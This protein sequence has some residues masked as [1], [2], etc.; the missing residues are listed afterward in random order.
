MKY[1]GRIFGSLGL[2]LLHSVYIFYYFF[3]DGEVEP[4]DLYSYPLLIWIGYWGGK[5]FDKVRFYSEKDELTGIYNRRFV[6]NTY[7]KITSIAERTN[8]KL[9]VLVID[10]DNFKAINDTYGHHNGDMVLIKISETLVDSTRKSDIVARWGG[11]EFLV[12]GLC[13][14]EADLQTILQRLEEHLKNLAYQ[15]NLPI[16]ASI[17]SA[18]YPNHSKD[19]F[20]LI[21]IADDKM[22]NSKETKSTLK[23]TKLQSQ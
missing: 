22:Y 23:I 16:K 9:Y 12:I 2:F 4:L 19:L 15:I 21:K 14:E 6:M 17:G 3:R 18:I 13:N 10:C 11:D 7:E 8:S 20:E 5:Q 1:T